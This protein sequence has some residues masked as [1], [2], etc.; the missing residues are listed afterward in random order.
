MKYY[1][2]SADNQ[3]VGDEDIPAFVG[4]AICLVM[5]T[6]LLCFVLK[7]FARARFVRP[8]RYANAAIPPPLTVSGMFQLHINQNKSKSMIIFVV[9]V[10]II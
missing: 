5:M 3:Q 7:M 10:F 2:T 9:H 6:G 4:L 1:S 8:R